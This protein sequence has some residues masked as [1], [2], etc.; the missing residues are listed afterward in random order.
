MLCKSGK[1]FWTNPADAE[2]CCNGYKRVLVLGGGE[3]QQEAGGVMCG[4][5]WV[6]ESLPNTVCTPT[7]GGLIHAQTESTPAAALGS[8]KSTRK[9][10]SSAENGKLGGR[11]KTKDKDAN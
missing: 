1:H 2:K 7:N 3:N 6:A 5:A 9:A 11:P 10:K 4:R 8:I